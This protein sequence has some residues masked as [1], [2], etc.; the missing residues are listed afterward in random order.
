MNMDRKE[1]Y[2]LLLL[3]LND[4]IDQKKRKEIGVIHSYIHRQQR[5]ASSKDSK[6]HAYIPKLGNTYICIYKHL[7][8]YWHAR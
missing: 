3:L 4:D 1:F 8:R 7:H 2:V 5:K 6:Q